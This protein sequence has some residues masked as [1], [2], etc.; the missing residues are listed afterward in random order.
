MHLQQLQRLRNPQMLAQHRRPRHHKLFGKVKRSQI[1]SQGS[2]WRSNGAA[3]AQAAQQAPM[4]VAAAQELEVQQVHQGVMGMLDAWKK[5]S[6]AFVLGRPL[7][8][9]PTAV[10]LIQVCKGDSERHALYAAATWRFHD[11]MLTIPSLQR[12]I[13]M[14]CVNTLIRDCHRCVAT[15]CV[16]A[17]ALCT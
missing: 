1:H 4:N 11:S 16:V 15:A 12:L 10:L 17:C 5:Q 14:R 3:P 6:G 7:T 8:R 2:L 13:F 9:H